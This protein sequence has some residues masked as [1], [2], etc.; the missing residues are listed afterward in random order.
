LICH[1]GLDPASIVACKPPW[2]ADRARN[3]RQQAEP[4]MA[5]IKNYTLNFVC[6]RALNARLTFAHRKL[7]CDEIQRGQ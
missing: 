1:A 2:I 5:E 7:A 6:G 4:T 3:D